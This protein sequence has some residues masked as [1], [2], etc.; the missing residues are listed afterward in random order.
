MTSQ[1]VHFEIKRLSNDE[2]IKISLKNLFKT[3][4][5]IPLMM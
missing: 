1:S 4:I 3:E 5:I 2:M